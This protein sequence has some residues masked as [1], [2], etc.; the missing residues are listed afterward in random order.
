MTDT[1]A[2]G[3]RSRRRSTTQ[4]TEAESDLPAAARQELAWALADIY[5][6][7]VDM[8]RDLQPNDVF[9]VLV[10]A[11]SRTAG[12]CAHRAILA[13]TFTRSGASIRPSA[14]RASRCAA[15]LRSG[16]QVDARRVPA[17]AARVPPHLQRVRHAQAPDP[18][19]LAAACGHRLRGV[20]GHASPRD[21]RRRRDLRGLEQWL[22]QRDRDPPSQRLRQPL[23]T[24][25][26]LRASDAAGA[27][28]RSVRPSDSSG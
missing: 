8:S 1:I 3:G 14:S 6:Y 22:R 28:S 20:A 7:R 4:S 9:R 2:V 19:H 26:R 16:R 17:R 11:A 24:P 12:R 27:Q 25:A 15:I 5:E 23:R 10:G 13:A 18:R 21:R